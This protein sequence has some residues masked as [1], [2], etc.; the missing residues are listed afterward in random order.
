MSAASEYTVIENDLI[1][2]VMP[3]P[4]MAAG[5]FMPLSFPANGSTWRVE[6]RQTP[7][8]PA[9]S[10]PCATVEGCDADGNFSLGFVQMFSQD[11]AAPFISID[12]QENGDF[13]Q[14]NN[15]SAYPAGYRSTHLITPET[16][17][18][19]KLR[20][21]NTGTDTA[22]TVVIRDTLSGLL[23]PASFRFQGSSH[24]CEVQIFGDRVLVCTFSGIQLPDSSANEP[25][26]HGFV[27]FSIDQMPGNPLGEVIENR[28]AI[29]FDYNVPVITNET[30][31]TIGEDFIADTDGVFT[32]PWQAKKL[33]VSP[34]PADGQV[35][36]RL[37]GIDGVEGQL[38]VYDQTGR[39][40]AGMVW[41]GTEIFVSAGQLTYR[42]ILRLV[43]VSEGKVVGMGEVV[44]E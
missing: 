18:D 14:S 10:R 21:Q 4:P 19:Y 44:A 33:L 39:L 2:T 37:E 1:K 38:R 5:D 12:C 9:G 22:Q 3:L 13:L 25:A 23:D 29:Y 15:K 7:F 26:S 40:V 24:P 28:A 42:G 27:Q 6:A 32:I 17:L 36:V 30:F 8:F 16:G 41:S 31:H 11:D 20:F 35:R 34:N 43:L